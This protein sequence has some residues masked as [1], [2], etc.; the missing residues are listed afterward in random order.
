MSVSNTNK[1]SKTNWAKV[2]SLADDDIDTSDSPELDRLFFE[3]ASVR[4][5]SQKAV[6]LHLDTDVLEWFKSQT[7]YETRINVALRLYAEAHKI[8]VR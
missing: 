2:D 1:S 5:P 3:R 7:A 6:V 4:L 8:Q